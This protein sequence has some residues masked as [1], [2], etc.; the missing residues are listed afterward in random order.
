MSLLNDLPHRLS[1]RT[2]DYAQ[3]DLGAVVGTFSDASTAVPGWVQNAGAAEIKQFD[4][5]DEVVSHK[6]FFRSD[7]GIVPGNQIYVESGPSFVGQTFE[8][9]AGAERSAGVGLLWAAYVRVWTERET[10]R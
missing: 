4:A 3:D 2:P 5:R 8:Y 1:I 7:P 6:V 10:G 9:V